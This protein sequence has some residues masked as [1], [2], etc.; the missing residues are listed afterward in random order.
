MSL[1]SETARTWGFVLADDAASND[2]HT[3]GA[4]KGYIVR[5]SDARAFEAAI[6]AEW[7]PPLRIRYPL[8]SNGDDRIKADQDYFDAIHRGPDTAL[9]ACLT[10]SPAP[11]HIDLLPEVQRR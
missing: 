7:W 6:K 1:P 10:V 2:D 5:T 4:I 8:S 11:M 9:E 3:T